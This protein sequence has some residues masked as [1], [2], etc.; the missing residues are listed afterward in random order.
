MIL[1]SSGVKRAEAMASGRFL[2]TG[3]WC[4]E[5][6][7]EA[8]QQAVRAGPWGRKGHEGKIAR[9]QNERDAESAGSATVERRGR[10]DASFE[11]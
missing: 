9:R 2:R 10:G 1:S 5:H 8:V 6:G 11:S 3:Y 4:T 7:A